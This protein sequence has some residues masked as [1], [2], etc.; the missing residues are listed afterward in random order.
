VTSAGAT[1]G[2]V[3]GKTVN[4]TP[5]RS[6]EPKSKATWRVVVRGALSGD[7]RLKVT[8]HTDQLALPEEQIVATRIYQQITNGN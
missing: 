2:S 3:I 4:F 8:M 1:A 6:L 7:A 5:L